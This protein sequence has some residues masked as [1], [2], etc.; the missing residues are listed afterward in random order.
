M[1]SQ[2]AHNDAHGADATDAPRIYAAC[3]SSYVAGRLVGRWIDANQDPDDLQAEVDAML[4]ASPEPG[5]E[6]FALH[7]FEGFHGIELHEYESLEDVSKL[8]AFVVEHGELGAAVHA[9]TGNLD[10]AIELLESCYQGEWDSLEAWAEDYLEQTGQ[11]AALPSQL[12][13]YFDYAAFG[14]DCEMNG[15]LFTVDVGGRTHVFW[16]R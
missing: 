14:R 16:S 8:A 3:L 7:D 11:L 15:D 9:H 4:A 10:E 2:H 1:S 12:R 6:E 13:M 5:A